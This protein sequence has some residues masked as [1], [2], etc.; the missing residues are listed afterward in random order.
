MKKYT[1]VSGTILLLILILTT[2]FFDKFNSGDNKNA[3]LSKYQ[4]PPHDTIIY[5]HTSSSL[6]IIL[7]QL[8]KEDLFNYNTLFYLSS[9][10]SSYNII[11]IDSLN[12][13][14]QSVEL[15]D[16]N[17]DGIEDILIHNTSSARS[18]ESY[19][20]YLV[21][22]TNNK[23]QKIRNFEKIPNPTF[24]SENNIITNYVLSGVNYTDFYKISGDSVIN[25]NI[26]IEDRR[27]DNDPD[28][29]VYYD[30]EY[31]KA[32]KKIRDIK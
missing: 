8:T 29:T 23:L 25:L 20:L 30:L 5:H 26:T 4:G 17:N 6:K 16:Y 31:E 10:D 27:F 13:Q 11:F 15:T 32:I 2:S 21:N 1:I 19:Y 18:N 24:D 22:N 14:T 28:N 12:C 9:N 3:L 7:V